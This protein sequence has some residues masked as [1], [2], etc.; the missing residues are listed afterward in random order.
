MARMMVRRR[1]AEPD[2]GVLVSRD[3]V[4]MV[5]TGE[6]TVA[7]LGALVDAV[8]DRGGAGGW[9]V[10]DVDTARALRAERTR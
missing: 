2:G 6:L 10:L 1:R 7:A 9:V 4:A 5:D 3:V 8:A